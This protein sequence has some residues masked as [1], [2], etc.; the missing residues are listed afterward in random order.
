MLL[1][2]K[3]RRL[4]SIE[5]VRDLF[6]P[7][8]PIPFEEYLTSGQNHDKIVAHIPARANS[9]RVKDKNIRKLNGLPLIAYSIIIAREMGADRI[10]L[11]TDS[12][13]YCCIGEQ[14]GA[15]CLFIRP[16]ELS[17][18][19]ISPG[20]AS[21]YATRK[22]LEDGYPA[23]YWVDMYPTS[24]FRSLSTMKRFLDTLRKAGTCISITTIQ[25][26]ARQ[27]YMPDKG[28][29]PVDLIYDDNRFFYKPTGTF[30]G[31]NLDH[32]QRFWKQYQTIVDPI[33]L[34]D[35][36]TEQDWELAESILENNLFDFGVE[37][38]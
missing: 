13:E 11:N 5:A 31:Q 23:G 6:F 26:P 22:V 14:Y 1:G 19:D 37:I 20:L 38:S 30:I 21:Y 18:D 7:D 12:E 9:V 25:P 27:V 16:A 35:I 33:E 34:I 10:I 28:S 8:T 4:D 36:D 24:P 17:R 15:E 32:K 29:T 3:N 2:S